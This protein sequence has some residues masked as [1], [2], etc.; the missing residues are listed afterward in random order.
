[1]SR[2]L[3]FLGIRN[4]YD[5]K[6]RDLEE[7][8]KGTAFCSQRSQKLYIIGKDSKAPKMPKKNKKR[9]EKAKDEKYKHTVSPPPRFPRS[10]TQ[11]LQ[12]L[13]REIESGA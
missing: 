10:H 5:N 6:A 2:G 9:K 12:L 11:F 8:Q 7:D 1:M 3:F 13:G 4:L